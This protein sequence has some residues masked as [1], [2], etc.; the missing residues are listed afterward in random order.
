MASPLRLPTLLLLGLLG[1][2]A[3]SPA[4]GHDLRIEREGDSLVLRYGHGSPGSHHAGPTGTEPGFVREAICFDAGGNPTPV[5]PE[6]GSPLRLPGDC[7]ATWALVST[8]YWTKTPA[9]TRN[10]PATEVE[11]ALSSRQSFESVKRLDA[12]TDALAQPLTSEL[13]IVPLVDPRAVTPGKKLDVRVVRDGRPVAGLP[14]SCDGRV[15]GQTGQDGTI[16][17]K[18]PEVELVLVQATVRDP[19]PGPEADEM[20]TTAGLVFETG[21]KE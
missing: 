15:R 9:G 19:H 11:H 1:L 12:W 20:V 17:L 16:R 5:T 7:A 18:V 3:A 13:E 21:G 10:L 14:V 2:L 6:A 8:G 4:R